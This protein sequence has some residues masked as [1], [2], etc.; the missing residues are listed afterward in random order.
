MLGYYDTTIAAVQD[1]PPTVPGARHIAV[2]EEDPGFLSE[3]G[4]PY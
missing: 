1:N 2:V 3:D 4:W